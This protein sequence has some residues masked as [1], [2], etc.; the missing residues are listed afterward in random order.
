MKP[1]RVYGGGPVDN[2][3]QAAFA[4]GVEALGLTLSAEVFSGLEIWMSE[5]LKWNQRVNLTAIIQPLEVVEKH[6]LD[7]LTVL[8]EIA[9]ATSL[10]D[11]GAGA[12]LPGIPL[13]VAL[14]SLSVTMVDAVNKKVAFLK[15]VI[16]KMGVGGRVRAVHL[17]ATGSPLTEGLAK[18][19]VVIARALMDVRQ[20]VP[21]AAPYLAPGGRLVAMLARQPPA[22][23][24]EELAH[25]NGLRLVSVRN[26]T[27]PLS[28]DPRSIAVFG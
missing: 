14:P 3:A 7:S 21:F 11:L 2:V 4:R 15:H 8:P 17:R 19:E 5:L 24:L 28:G 12:G 26:F 22:A 27:L 25:R 13:A 16:V 20:W 23:G 1:G 10:L 9:G 6:M 18:A